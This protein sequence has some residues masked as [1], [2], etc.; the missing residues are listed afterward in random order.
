M[1]EMNILFMS[2]VVG[3]I[4]QIIKVLAPSD[5]VQGAITIAVALVV[6]V[7]T[8]L[9]AGFLGLNEMSIA[10]GLIGA[11]TAIGGVSTAKEILKEDK[12]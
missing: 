2:I 6:G 5:Q 11:L 9:L 8:A 12:L 3:A 1:E 4:T 7:S 10:E